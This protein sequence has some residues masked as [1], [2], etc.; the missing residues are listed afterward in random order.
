M[1]RVQ[2]YGKKA[3]IHEFEVLDIKSDRN[4]VLG[5]DILD[6]LGVAI[7]G[8][9]TQFAIVDSE[10]QDSSMTQDD[11]PI[12][13]HIQTEV[14]KELKEK[15]ALKLARIL[16]S[17]FN[18][19]VSS[20]Y[21]QTL[22]AFQ[23][24][25]P[26]H[27]HSYIQANEAIQGFCSH[28][29]AFIELDIGHHEPIHKRQYNLAKCHHTFIHQ[30]VQT[31]L[32]A[33]IIQ[34]VSRNTAWNNPLLIVPKKDIDGST[35]RWRLCIDPR[36]INS[37]IKSC[38]YPL[39]LIRDLLE[40]LSGSRV[41][42]RIDLK[43]S[44]NQFQVHPEHREY[45]TFTWNTIQYQFIGAP[46]G[47]KHVS[48]VFQRVMNDIFV[49]LSFVKVY[50]DD[51]IIC[52][53][54]YEIHLTHL[55]TVL[56]TLNSFNLKANMLKSVLAERDI[57][58]L[59]YKVNQDGIR[60][61]AEKLAV[62]EDWKPPSTGKSL[63]Q[64]LGFF[65]FF[66]E[67][68]P[69]YASLVAPLDSLRH[70]EKITWTESHQAIYS[71]LKKILKSELILSFPSYNHEFIVA[72]DASDKGLGAV[73][74]QEIN[75]QNHYL[76][77]A[78][79]SLKGGERN[80]G[81]TKRELLGIVFALEKFRNYILGT[82]FTLYTDHHSLI[83]L[84]SQKHSNRM[85]N[86]WI[87][88]LSEFDFKIFHRPGIQNILPD[89]LSRLY[90]FEGK[91]DKKPEIIYSIASRDPTDLSEVPLDQRKSLVEMAHSKGHFGASAMRSQ[92][93]ADGWIWEGM[94]KDLLGIV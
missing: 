10:T 49:D 72:T 37:I 79:R 3:F 39:P 80:Y 54:S 76:S 26:L 36:P 30:Q 29:Q 89:R 23:V 82:P 67:M 50:I 5:I 63:Q 93:L 12:T 73:L 20:T 33:G 24:S 19:K 59:G 9:P 4:C 38:N 8:I 13:T 75:G 56:T 81:A 91:E 11:T 60:V 42:S 84:H 16:D 41:F 47:L 66:R 65:N 17:S 32:E 6:K 53:D 86:S 69:N 25:I 68:I 21:A 83:F 35:K 78:S 57:I 51:I 87:D 43:S 71:K 55:E 85:I 88:V 70:H 34:R 64:H 45:T 58:I 90:D 92:L 27:L 28:P 48:S 44:F 61:A 62:I 40:S 94:N 7:Q 15:G 18:N 14:T 1:V 77:F 22:C 46:F 52:S 74:Y 31:W 2:V